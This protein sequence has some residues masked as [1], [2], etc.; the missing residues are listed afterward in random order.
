MTDPTRSTARGRSPTLAAA[1]SA[2]LSMAGTASA[3]ETVGLE[4]I[5]V[6]ATRRAERLQDVS[7]SISAFDANAI[8]MRGLQQMD[9]IVK[10]IPGMSIAQRE[11]GGTTLI[12]RGVASSGIQF[13]AV[14]SSA[15]YLDEQPITQSGRNPDPRLIDIE[16]VE[17]LRGPQGTLYGA[18][19][20]SGTLRV[21]TAQPD[22]TGFAAWTEAQVNS[23]SDG[24]T[25]YDLS[26]MVNIPLAADRVALRVVGFT[27]EDAGYIDNV[28][29]P[30][31][32]GTFDNADF[33]ERDINTVETTGARAALRFDFTESVNAT[34]GAIYQDMKA[35]GHSDVNPGRGDLTQVR[36][37]EE[38]LDD[39][40][41]Q[42]GL[43]VNAGTPIGDLVIS[44]SYFDRDF[45]YEADASDYEFAF[46]QAAIYTG[47]EF[48]NFGGDPRGFAQ[49][50]EQTEITTFEARLQSPA[51][52]DSRWSWLVGAFYSKEEGHTQFDSFVRGYADTPAFSYISYLEYYYNGEFLEPTDQWW[53]GLYDTE[54]EQR[55]VFGEVAFD[56]TENFTITAGAR[57]FE[58]ERFFALHQ[59]APVGFDG[60]PSTTFT[61]EVADTEESGSVAKLNLTYRFDDDR[62]I[63][64]TY[65][66]GFRN[67]G[68]N[69]VRPASILPRSFASD[70][71]TNIEFGAKTEWLDNRLRLNIALYSMEWDDFAVQIEDPQDLVF[72]LGYVNLPS[73]EI[74]GIESE[75]SFAI[76]EAWQLDA[77]LGYN[78]AEVSE[79]VVLQF[80]PDTDPIPVTKGARLPLTPD[81]SASLGIEYRSPGRLLNAQPFARLDLAYV[82]ESV[83]NLEGIESVVAPGGVQVQEAYDTG[84][85]R[86]GL[87]AENWSASL[88]VDNVWDERANLFLSN[89]WAVQRQSIN[90]P[91]TIG[92]QFRYHF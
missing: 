75:F 28:L 29:S 88:F 20:Q 53:I 48:Y 26:A 49:N 46:N 23:V 8:S 10:Y 50:D 56:L 17:A 7:E 45:H 51:D 18:S 84:D 64:A 9:D 66:E 25:G 86:I 21:I 78:D 70:E 16:R 63:Y 57:W 5:I 42:I 14:S 85:F 72:Q 39:R 6:T 44:A 69:P 11:P 65:S 55:A 77:T 32:G 89:R 30:S 31:Q 61:D 37:E 24:D 3:Q 82:G 80:T 1:V 40:W 92:L 83:N 74:Q 52:S 27:A 19:S 22:P 67:G 12:F 34:L 33:V 60:G 59:E 35:D 68:T 71:L 36:F 41:Y 15:L 2:V 38:T 90:R 76:S 91:R 87:E 58:Y 62:L 47:Y 81:W 79:A 13:G 43:T 73:A 4:E 54:L